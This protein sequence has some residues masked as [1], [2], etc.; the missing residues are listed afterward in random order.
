M[1]TST[2]WPTC[3]FG[4][5]RSPWCSRSRRSP[6]WSTGSISGQVV[7]SGGT[8]T[9][10]LPRRSELLEVDA[11]GGGVGDVSPDLLC[12]F[13]VTEGI[14]AARTKNKTALTCTNADQ[15][16]DQGSHLQRRPRLTVAI[17]G[18]GGNRTRVGHFVSSLV[19]A[20]NGALTWENTCPMV[21]AL[22]HDN[23]RF[24]V[25]SVSSLCQLCQF[26]VS[27]AP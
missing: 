19:R 18:G 22:D 21:T 15:G 6:Q 9:R 20:S 23:P 26:R 17:L 13:R 16:N 14:L 27:P 2:S 8:G 25:I 1:T 7:P 11:D 10:R 4:A 24:C 3:H 5:H 12:Q